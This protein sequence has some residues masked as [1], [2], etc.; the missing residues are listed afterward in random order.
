MGSMSLHSSKSDASGLETNARAFAPAKV[1]LC[2]RCKLLLTSLP[3][4]IP[5]R[6]PHQSLGGKRVTAIAPA[7]GDSCVDHRGHREF[8]FVW[9]VFLDSDFATPSRFWPWGPWR[10]VSAHPEGE[11]LGCT[12]FGESHPSE[13]WKSSDLF[14]RERRWNQELGTIQTSSSSH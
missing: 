6:E 3:V 1:T 5:H 10:S 12:S 7:L 13:T 14:Y 11:H 8:D 9:T 4:L 2:P